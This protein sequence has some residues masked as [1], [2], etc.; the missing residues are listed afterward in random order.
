VRWFSGGMLDLMP[1]EKD[2]LTAK[3][4]T[5]YITGIIFKTKNDRKISINEVIP[6]AWLG[7]LIKLHVDEKISKRDLRSIIDYVCEN[8]SIG[9]N[10]V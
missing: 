5:N 4:A 8:Y 1:S 2:I 10:N 9:V 3:L 6:P 7:F